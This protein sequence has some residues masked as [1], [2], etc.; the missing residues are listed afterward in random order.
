MVPMEPDGNKGTE[1]LTGVKASKEMV[2]SI[3]WSSQGVE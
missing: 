3:G 2:D 1:D